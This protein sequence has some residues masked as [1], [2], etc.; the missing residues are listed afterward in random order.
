[1]ESKKI[2]Q[3]KGYVKQKQTHRY[4]KQNS[5]YQIGEERK[6]DRLRMWK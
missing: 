5:G 2:I 3:M 1:M 6:E 4:R